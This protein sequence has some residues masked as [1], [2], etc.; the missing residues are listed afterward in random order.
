MNR[1]VLI[2]IL[3]ALAAATDFAR[4][5]M[6]PDRRIGWLL[7][8]AVSFRDADFDSALKHL[9]RKAEDSSGGVVKFTIV[10]ELAEDYRP[11]VTLEL[12][13]V[14]FTVALGY[15]GDMA[16]VEV[17]VA[18]SRVIVRPL[19]ASPATRPATAWR[20][21]VRRPLPPNRLDL[22][23]WPAYAGRYVWRGSD[24]TVIPAKSG[25]IAHRCPEGFAIGSRDC[26]CAARSRPIPQKVAAAAPGAAVYAKEWSVDPA[27][28]EKL[29]G[30]DLSINGVKAAL[31]RRGISFPAGSAAIWVPASG[32]LIVR[33]T[34]ANLE[35]LNTILPAPK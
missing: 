33:N 31:I 30:G 8:P 17:I 26:I 11:R 19:A 10:N 2:V 7:L 32:K 20:P 1:V 25:Y 24:G 5:E 21:E 12:E 6:A 3:A 23:A 28:M 13:R 4:A 16:R 27:W 14:P 34:T 22:P 29:A 18:G 9:V 15:L 35:S